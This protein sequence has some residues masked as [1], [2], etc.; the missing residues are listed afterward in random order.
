MQTLPAADADAELAELKEYLGGAYDQR[1]L[2]RWED[3]VTEE[4]ARLGDEAELYRRSEAYLYNL[5][6]F[7]MSGTKDPYLAEIARRFPRGT[8]LLD[9]GCGI[10]SDGLRLLE[11]GYD[12]SF[13]DFDNPSVEYLRWRLRRRGLDAR[14]FDL[15]RERPSGFELAYAFDVLEHVDDPPAFLSSMAAAADNVLVN[16]LEDEDP[17]D[18]PLHRDVP[19][20][21]LLRGV[22]AHPVVSYSVHHG[23]AH[24]VL[25]R[26]RSASPAERVRSMLAVGRGARPGDLPAILLPIPWGYRPWRRV[27]DGNQHR[28]ADAG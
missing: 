19:I 24:L 4:Y 1:R 6:V 9:Y 16:F 15:D 25:Y 26:S 17:G 8:R 12:V 20:G 3:E 22:T 11:A 7:A 27:S 23:R 18:N 13:A 10:G 28:H 2:E 14:I 21:A 5:T